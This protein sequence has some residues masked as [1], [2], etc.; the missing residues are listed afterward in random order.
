[1]EINTRDVLR[2]IELV[3]K[4]ESKKGRRF[5]F[6]QQEGMLFGDVCWWDGRC[7]VW[8]KMVAH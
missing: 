6:A 5:S 7:R 8:S 3:G 4:E 1:M 2:D